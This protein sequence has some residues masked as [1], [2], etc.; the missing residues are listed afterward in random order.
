MA[1]ASGLWLK[2]LAMSAAVA[3]LY[4]EYIYMG[5][6]DTHSIH[7][8][9]SQLTLLVFER[10]SG[11]LPRVP[12]SEML[13]NEITSLLQPRIRLN[14]SADKLPESAKERAKLADV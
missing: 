13:L 12:S 1:G 4:C 3:I 9:M 6:S 2:L 8:T 5:R 14:E 7:Y 10:A 11:R